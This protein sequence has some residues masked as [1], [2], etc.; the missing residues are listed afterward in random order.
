MTFAERVQRLSAFGFTERQA[1]FLVTVMLHAGVCVERQYCAAAGLVHGQVTRDFFH[2]LVAKRHAT[3]HSCGRRGARVYHIHAK[4]LYEAI[5]EPNNR[6]RRPM[7]LGR[8]IERLM[9]LDAVLAEPQLRWLATEHDKLAHFTMTTQ[10]RRDELPQLVFRNDTSQTVRY[11][12]DK[13]PIGLH[14]DGRTHVFLYSVHRAAPADFRVFLYRHATLWRALSRWTVRLLI[15]PHLQTVALDYQRAGEEELGVRLAPE[16]VEELRWFFHQRRRAMGD[17]AA[18]SVTDTPRF[19]RARR[20]FGAPRYRVLY[21]QWLLA[22][23]PLIN[24]LLSPVLP[25]AVIRG[26]GQVETH[27]LARPYHHLSPLVGTA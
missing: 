14:P 7:A 4:R 1:T 11:F 2:D 6:H 9:V 21:R 23:E 18:I 20:A 25:D 17:P 22:G 5:G 3:A 13:L 27:V 12:P 24:A 10:L 16:T 8:A 19:R 26:T 15:P